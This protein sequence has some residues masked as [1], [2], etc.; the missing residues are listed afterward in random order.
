MP[1][2][3][4]PILESVSKTHFSEAFDLAARLYGRVLLR[5]VRSHTAVR[6]FCGALAA[7]VREAR[8]DPETA[9]AMCR[10]VGIKGKRL[11]V[12][13]TRLIAGRRN[14]QSQDQI[15]RW[16]NAAAYVAHPLNGDVVP[17]DWRE[18]ARYITRRGGI[19]RLS[20]LYAQR[21]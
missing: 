2:D 21:A 13:V 12:R 3:S 20:N 8:H 7:A 9:N 1:L 10:K 5:D 17:Q 4:T 15:A 14:R 19:R 18:A 11:E 6:M 16:A